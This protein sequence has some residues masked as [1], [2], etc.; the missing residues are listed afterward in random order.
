MT[1]RVRS[2]IFRTAADKQTF[3]DKKAPQGKK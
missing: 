1:T 3:E 2:A